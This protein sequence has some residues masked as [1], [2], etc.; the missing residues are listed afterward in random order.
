MIT[1]KLYAEAIKSIV[2]LILNTRF[3]ENVGGKILIRSFLSNV[4]FSRGT[5][6]NPIMY[7]G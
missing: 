2:F 1:Y 7:M 4:Y 5:I 3:L 6:F